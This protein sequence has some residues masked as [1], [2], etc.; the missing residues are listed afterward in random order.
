MT[1]ST[2]D[3]SSDASSGPCADPP[4]AAAPR[5]GTHLSASALALRQH[6]LPRFWLGLTLGLVL[7]GLGGAWWWQRQLPQRLARAA[8]R[9]DLEACLRFGEQLEALRWPQG[10]SPQEHGRCRRRQAEQLWQQRRWGEALRLQLQLAN[11]TVAVAADRRRLLDWQA[12]LQ[13]RALE[14]FQQGELEQALALLAPMG[15]DHRADGTA[16]GD[17]LRESWTRNR[18][19]AERA[20]RLVNQQRWWEALE[21]L[22]RIDHPWWRQRSGPSRTRVQAGIQSLEG[23]ERE[24]DGHGSLPH[25]VSADQLDAE[26]RRRIA[27]GVDE[28]QA[29]QGACAALGGRVVEAGPETACQR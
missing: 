17:R 8:A 26:V 18:L 16:L 13:R 1:C 20:Q 14:R 12:D 15:E 9:G 25:T 27:D 23:R 21:A 5:T 19:Q 29:F 28:W 11:S 3:P 22:N 24:H 7:A 6:R 2:T 10:S 4:L